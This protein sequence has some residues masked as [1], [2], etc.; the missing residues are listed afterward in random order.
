M[1]G[2]D[3]SPIFRDGSNQS[4][5]SGGTGR[6]GRIIMSK[7]SIRARR[8]VSASALTLAMLL[9]PALGAHGANPGSAAGYT[10]EEIHAHKDSRPGAFAEYREN[11]LRHNLGHHN[12]HH[13]SARAFL[14]R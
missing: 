5:G 2:M 8:I 13:G 10:P 11:G 9:A 1:M 6:R 4:R 3:N 14:P 7:A 12:R